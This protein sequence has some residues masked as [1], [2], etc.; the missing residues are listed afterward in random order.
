MKMALKHCFH[1]NDLQFIKNF[2]L[3]IIVGKKFFYLYNFVY[4]CIVHC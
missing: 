2:F 3:T 4:L 1:P